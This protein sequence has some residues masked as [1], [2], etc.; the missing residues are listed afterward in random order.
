VTAEP[1]RFYLPARGDP[2]CGRGE[3]DA[4]SDTAVTLS[5][6]ILAA[7]AVIA[8]V[9]PFDIYSTA[10]ERANVTSGKFVDATQHSG[11]SFLHR[12]SPTSK[13]YLPETMGSG[14]AL[15]DYD[16]DGLLDLYLVN[17]AP[18]AGP[19]LPGAIPKKDGPSYWNRLYYQRKDGAFEDVT[20]HAGVA[21]YGY[22]MGVAVGDYD[23]DGYEDLYV[24]EYEHNILYHKQQ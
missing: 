22:E 15:F 19:T 16:N 17:G 14:V 8:A 21:G 20:E 24:T 7:G 12:A 10:D 2:Q 11:V 3:N 6:F 9:L 5:R 4:V 1:D 13:K 18:I 23:N